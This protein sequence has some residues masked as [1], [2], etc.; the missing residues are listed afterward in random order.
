MVAACSPA[1]DDGVK[2]ITGEVST[3]AGSSKGFAD[4][5]GMEAK[6][7]GLSGLTVDAGG[8]IY[9]ADLKNNAIRKVTPQGIVTTFAGGKEGDDN[10]TGT[11][12]EF[13]GPHDI[14][15]GADGNFYVVEVYGNRIRK[16]SPAG[17]VSNFAGSVTGELAYLD[18]SGNEARF[19]SPRCLTVGTDGSFY[20]TEFSNRI[21]KVTAGGMVSTFAG[22]GIKGTGDGVGMN[23]TFDD[24]MGIAADQQGNV[25][26]AQYQSSAIR[27]ITPNGVVTTPDLAQWPPDLVVDENS[28]LFII[29][30]VAWSITMLTADQKK[31]T[32]AGSNMQGPTDGAWNL[33]RF[34]IPYALHFDKT[35]NIL[36]VSDNDRIRKVVLNR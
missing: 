24:P 33:A 10:G 16:I 6:F 36:Y 21:R 26:V 30:G 7:N 1:E 28:N 29:D 27:K 34:D 25:Y 5:T 23:A 9:V 35:E 19:Y 13:N 31:S 8:N 18:G 12:A 17:V 15:I 14:E 22:S 32:V 11:A 4:G 20:I 2:Q 3:L